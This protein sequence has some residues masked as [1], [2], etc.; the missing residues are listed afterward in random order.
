MPLVCL[1]RDQFRT[2]QSIDRH[3]R[4]CIPMLPFCLWSYAIATGKSAEAPVDPWTT[5][6]CLAAS[7][8]RHARKFHNFSSPNTTS[9]N[10]MRRLDRLFEDSVVLIDAVGL[11]FHLS[12]ARRLLVIAK[13]DRYFGLAAR[14]CDDAIRSPPGTFEVS[15]HVARGVAA[16]RS[17]RAQSQLLRRGT[18]ACSSRRRARRL[19]VRP[20]LSGAWP[21][22][23]RPV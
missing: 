19:A 4:L 3:I 16:L 18:R 5:R 7:R 9:L 14:H 1:G 11:A 12:P 2:G 8:W 20:I 10:Q 21:E 22:Y 23:K 13:P 6:N 17:R 15:A